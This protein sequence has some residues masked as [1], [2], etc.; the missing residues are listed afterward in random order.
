[1]RELSQLLRSNTKFKHLQLVVAVS[2]RLHIGKV[3]EQ[4]HLSQPTVS[5]T[6]AE[7]ESLVG[8]RLFERTPAGLVETPQGKAFTQFAR[9]MLVRIGRMG[10]GVSA[11]QLGYAGTV[12]VGAQISGTAV[13]VPMAVKLLKQKS[14][15]TTVRLDDGLI[16]PLMEKLR[17]GES[18]LVIGRVDAIQDTT[19]IAV[20]TL[21]QDVVVAVAAPKAA[22]ARKRRLEWL[23]LADCPWILPPPESSAR[24]RIDDEA[25]QLGL[26]IPKDLVETGSFLAMLMLLRERDCVCLFPEHLAKYCEAALLVKVLPL[27]PIHMGSPIG[28]ARLEGRRPRPAIALFMEC[29]R[30]ASK[31]TRSGSSSSR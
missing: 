30:E 20:E 10:E 4:M 27:P 15:G 26:P 9:E 1:M 25:R 3:A 14:P 18:D 22:V 7:I 11:A 13:L 31:L 6:L 24:R 12:T 23:D 21:Y 29:L 8:V 19:G 16:E 28:I 5:K 17:F 2:D